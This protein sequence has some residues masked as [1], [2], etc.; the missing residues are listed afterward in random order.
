MSAITNP[1]VYILIPA[2]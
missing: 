1:D 2:L